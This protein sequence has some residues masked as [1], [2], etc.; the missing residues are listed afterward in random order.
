MVKEALFFIII[1]LMRRA[2]MLVHHTHITHTTT[3][4]QDRISSLPL[5]LGLQGHKPSAYFCT[6]FTVR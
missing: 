4:I 5:L 3:H 1:K 2:P 6:Y